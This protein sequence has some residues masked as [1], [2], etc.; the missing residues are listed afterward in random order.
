MT[1]AEFRNLLA[2]TKNTK[3]F[4]NYVFHIKYYHINLQFNFK[5]FANFYKFI[6]EQSIGWEGMSNK[7]PSNVVNS[8]KIYKS[9]ENEIINFIQKYSHIDSDS[10]LEINFRDLKRSIEKSLE[11]KFTF[12]CP[13]ILFLVDVYETHYNSFNA[14]YNYLAGNNNLNLNNRD[15]F[16]GYFLAS[17]FLLRD[18]SEITERINKEK[19]SLSRLRSRFESSFSEMENQLIEHLKNNNAKT[20]EYIDRLESDITKINKNFT[21]WFS[22]SDTNLE[23]FTSRSENKVKQLENLYQEKLKLEEPAKYWSKRGEKLKK[24]GWFSLAVLLVLVLVIVISLKDL[25]WRT[26]EQIY[27]SFFNGDKS[28]AIRW[29]IIYITFIS[30]MAFAIRAITKVMFSSFHLARDCEE[31]YTLTYFY[32][33]LLKDSS[34]DKDDKKL[35]MQS[36]F[37]RAETGLLKDDSSP[38]MPND[39]VGKFMS[40]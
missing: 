20:Q 28:A 2:E 10:T 26:P 8:N 39:I 18:S 14:S 9:I 16:K 35:I 7:L 12:D 34:V 21:N 30:F 23:Q 22:D 15:D 3:W 38:T 1:Q 37:S 4:N 36:L 6:N 17:E 11:N 24:Q 32:L 31:R 40:K 25:L 33:S 29:S 19:P 5:G 27:S 13:E